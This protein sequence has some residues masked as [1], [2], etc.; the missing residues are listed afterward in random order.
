MKWLNYQKLEKYFHYRLLENY[1][2]NNKKV[3]YLIFEILKTN[4]YKF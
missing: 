1:Q 3:K 4:H 2:E